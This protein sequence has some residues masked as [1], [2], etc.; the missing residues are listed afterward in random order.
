MNRVTNR[1]KRQKE[2]N[3]DAVIVAFVVV[4]FFSVADIVVVAS[5]GCCCCGH[6]FFSV[7]MYVKYGP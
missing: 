7:I 3:I 5:I 1:L 2:T 4:V 6:C